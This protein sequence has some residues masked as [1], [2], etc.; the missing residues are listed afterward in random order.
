MSEEH[1]G[2][3]SLEKLPELRRKTENISRFLQQQIAAHLE[4]LRPLF[5]P[6]RIF[7]KHAGGKT[8][9]TGTEKA[10][11]ELQQNY[12]PFS[13]PPYDLPGT[14]DTSW[15]TLVGSALELHPWEYTHSAQGK[16]VLMTSPVRWVVNYRANYSLAQV[17]TVLSG[18]ETVRPEYLRQFVINMLVLQIALSRNPGLVQL[19]Q[20]LRYEV[21]TESPPDLKGLPVV[22]ITST[23]NS[24][25]PADDLIVAATAFSGVP[26]F[27]ELLDTDAIR[28]AADPLQ[29][30]LD[31]LLK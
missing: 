21:K 10:L 12:K 17:K 29:A 25:R 2:A 9:V 15:L 30:K 28:Q 8:D 22:T 18:K 31:T 6:E 19:F 13:R 11:L 27:I 26:A 5:A 4:T 1:A 3:V 7:G 24:F 23:L 16:A 20:D 14:L